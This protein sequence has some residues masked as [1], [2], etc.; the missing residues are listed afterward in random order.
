MSVIVF[1]NIYVIN[2]YNNNQLMISLLILIG[3]MINT[4]NCSGNINCD[5]LF[6]RV[7]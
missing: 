3:L 1:V 6:L 7:Y 4:N 5:H 2:I